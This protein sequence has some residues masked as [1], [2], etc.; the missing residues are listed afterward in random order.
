MKHTLLGIGTIR[1]PQVVASPIS[2]NR[3]HY[4]EIDNL[5]FL[6][7]YIVGISTRGANTCNPPSNPVACI[8]H[9][10]LTTLSCPILPGF[11]HNQ[12]LQNCLPWKFWH[13]L[14]LVHQRY[15]FQVSQLCKK[16]ILFYK[17]LQHYHL[18]RSHWAIFLPNTPKFCGYSH[19]GSFVRATLL[20]LWA[21]TRAHA[22]STRTE[23][24][25]M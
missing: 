19:T 6:A 12:R 16:F 15:N 17:F 2:L 22:A 25:S 23:F 9:S 7:G 21:C 18:M 24:V 11:H 8:F 3:W 5:S 10:K 13:L 14:W 20:R 4:C 1:D